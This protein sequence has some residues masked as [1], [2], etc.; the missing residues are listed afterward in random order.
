MYRKGFFLVDVVIGIVLLCLWTC[1]LAAWYQQVQS[2]KQ[3]STKRLQALCLASSLLN[4]Y[5]ATKK[6]P[7]G[8]QEG[9]TITWLVKNDPQIPTFKHITLTLAWQLKSIRQDLS[10]ETGIAL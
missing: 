1:L 9:Y 7:T 3:Q 10:I 6:Q 2:Q 8:T 4:E 5:R